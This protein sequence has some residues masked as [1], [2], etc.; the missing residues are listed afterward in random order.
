LGSIT[1]VKG[2]DETTHR[3]STIKQ[4]RSPATTPTV[5]ETTIPK[6]RSFIKSLSILTPG[7]YLCYNK[8]TLFKTKDMPRKPAS[9]PQGDNVNDYKSLVDF[10]GPKF[11]KIDKSFEK[12]DQR[13]EKIDQRFEKIDQR[14]EKIGIQLSLK[15]DSAQIDKVNERIDKVYDE[16]LTHIDGLAKKIDDYQTEQ[17]M[18]SNQLTRHEKWHFRV[19]SKVGVD[20]LDE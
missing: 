6:I 17:A 11:E 16:L 19:A 7:K 9:K 20:L 8:T 4:F 10:L 14:F 5:S 12:I 3:N 1:G 2:E 18:M 15:A 13:F